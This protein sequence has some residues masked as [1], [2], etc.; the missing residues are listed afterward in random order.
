ME[1]QKEHPLIFYPHRNTSNKSEKEDY[2]KKIKM[3]KKEIE[4]E[5]QWLGAQVNELSD[6]L[7]VIKNHKDL[8]K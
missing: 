5:Y 4:Y 7:Q 2:I 6:L 3:K 8:K 1:I